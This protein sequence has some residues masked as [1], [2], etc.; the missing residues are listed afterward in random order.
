MG[1]LRLVEGLD[2]IPRLLIMS[3]MLCT[4]ELDSPPASTVESY[5]FVGWDVLFLTVSPSGPFF[6]SKEE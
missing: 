2:L 4:A 1:K 5:A 6:S 3:W